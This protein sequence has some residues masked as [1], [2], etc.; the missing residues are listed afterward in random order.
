MAMFSRWVMMDG[1]K[2]A[3]LLLAL[4][5]RLKMDARK[6]LRC[7]STSTSSFRHRR[8]FVKDLMPFFTDF[9]NPMMFLLLLLL[10]MLLFFRLTL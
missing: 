2:F 10:L 5:V 8:V 4:C 6:D 3:S 9:K 1:M 7:T